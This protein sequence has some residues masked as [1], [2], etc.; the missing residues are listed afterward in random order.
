MGKAT[1]FSTLNSSVPFLSFIESCGLV[2]NKTIYRNSNEKYS[3]TNTVVIRGVVVH[4]EFKIGIGSENIPFL[5]WYRGTCN[6][7]RVGVCFPTEK[8]CSGICIPNIVLEKVFFVLLKSCW[9]FLFYFTVTKLRQV[10]LMWIGLY[11][12]TKSLFMN[13]DNF[14]IFLG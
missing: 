11:V 2:Y 9:K 5:V 7:S 1:F 8:W 4:F 14:Q 12:T 13:S 10:A 3:I 6:C